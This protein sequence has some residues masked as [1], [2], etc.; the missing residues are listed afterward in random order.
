MEA[1]GPPGSKNQT[2][3]TTGV[4]YDQYHCTPSLIPVVLQQK[5]F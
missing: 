2:L 5:P 4:R 1:P 3:I